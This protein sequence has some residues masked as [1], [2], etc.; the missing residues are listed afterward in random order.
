MEFDGAA[1]EVRGGAGSKQRRAAQAEPDFLALQVRPG[2][3]LLVDQRIAGV[4]GPVHRAQGAE[5]DHH[6]GDEDGPALAA[7]A[8]HAA[9]GVG[10]RERNRQQEQDLDVIRQRR[11]VLVGMGRVGIEE[12]AAVGAQLLDRLEG[13]HRPHG[14]GLGI[15]RAAVFVLDRLDQGGLLVAAEILDDALRGQ[16]HTGDQ[17]DRQEDVDNAPG[18]IDPEA[19]DLLRRPADD[20][21]NK[22][23]DY[24]HAGG[25]GQELQQHQAPAGSDSWPP[26]RPNKPASWYW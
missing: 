22:G 4:L 15:D 6:H 21:A 19:A 16:E 17:G 23:D 1:V 11:G 25:G 10:Q 14:Q 13:G 20:A 26:I 18:E 5:Q 2:D 9:K 24:G 7:V 8:H 12:T 3:P